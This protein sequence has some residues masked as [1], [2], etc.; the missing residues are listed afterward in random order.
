MKKILFLIFMWIG[1]LFST[2]KIFLFDM[3]SEN[4]PCLENFIKITEKDMYQSGKYGWETKNC[5]SFDQNFSEYGVGSL[6]LDPLLRDLVKS[7]SSL[8]IIFSVDVSKGK[9]R[10]GIISG[11]IYSGNRLLA[12]SFWYSGGYIKL[13]DKKIFEKEGDFIKYAKFIFSN[14]EKD[15]LPGDSLFKRYILPYYNIITASTDETEKIRIEFSNFFPVNGIII[16]PEEKI[17]EFNRKL[18]EIFENSRKYIDEKLK[19][20]EEKRDENLIKKY[21]NENF[22][23]FLTQY[24]EKLTPYSIP[25][26]E[27]INQPVKKI[28]A[29]GENITL[30]FGILPINDLKEV[31]L[32]ISDLIS[33]TKEK[34]SGKNATF[35]ITK[36]IPELLRKSPDKYMIEEKYAIRYKKSDFASLIPRKILVLFEIPEDIKEGEYKG[37]IFVKSGNY[38]KE[39]PVSIKV[40]PFK[41][42]ESDIYFGMYGKY[43]RSSLFRYI[44]KED[45]EFIDF[46]DILMEN[47]FKEMRQ[48]GFNWA[49]IELPWN[50]LIIKGNAIEVTPVLKRWEAIY[51][52]YKKY[53]PKA[54]FIIYGQIS[55]VFPRGDVNIWRKTGFTEEIKNQM[56]MTADWISDYFEKEKNERDIAIYISD[57]L[58]NYGLEGGKFG[59]E[60]ASLIRKILEGKNIKLFASMNGVPEH[61]MIPYLDFSVINF[62]FPITEETITKIKDAGSK[63]VF[64]NIGNNRFS[65]GFY[66]AKLHPFGR[67]QWNFGPEHYV[68]YNFPSFPTL[69]H[70]N[71]SLIVDSEFN[72]GKRLDVIDMS[73]GVIDYRYY[74]TLKNLIDKN[75]NTKNEKLREILNKAEGFLKYITESIKTDIRYYTKEASVWSGETCEKIRVM[76]TNYIMEVLNASK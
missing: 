8:P 10:V 9:Y 22:L 32:E 45:K 70:I 31:E 46:C 1:F 53:F 66:I 4:S 20:V 14:F 40:L 16:Y 41:L 71:Y 33:D 76:L 3:G 34:I 61:L 25:D 65:Y 24:Y 49:C 42:Q 17:I 13:N 55:P 30:S 2:D 43:P 21:K 74:L 47:I 23:L 58:S 5:L 54:P 56:Q 15:F 48:L 63:L 29:K 44:T 39:L 35:W 18:E 26:E 50:P 52:L 19:I 60:H 62:D 59:A 67:L 69:G 57:E 73:E 75:K 12:P 68:F 28:C 38:V 11:Q 36:F 51:S 7:N 27:K 6:D 64:Y 37:K 72:L